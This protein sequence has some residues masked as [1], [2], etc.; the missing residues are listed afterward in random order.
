M[1]GLFS[2]LSSKKNLEANL[3]IS[4]IECHWVE[5]SQRCLMWFLL[6][7]EGES[8]N[9]FA[10][11]NAEYEP[12][13]TCWIV[14]GRILGKVVAMIWQIAQFATLWL[15]LGFGVVSWAQ[16]V[17][18]CVLRGNNQF[19]LNDDTNCFKLEC[20]KPKQILWLILVGCVLMLHV[21]MQ[22]CF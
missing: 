14:L 1:W 10:W 2:P 17:G 16:K 19:I 22:S 7:C 15:E 3:A 20:V 13:A 18:C 9:C 8:Q 4:W 5:G 21:C 6:W 11:G 12:L